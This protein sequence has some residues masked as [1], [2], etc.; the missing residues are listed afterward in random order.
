METE[1]T[2]WHL[3]LTLNALIGFMTQAVNLGLCFYFL[4]LCSPAQDCTEVM[5]DR[6]RAPR[7]GADA[8]SALDKL[9][10]C[11]DSSL[12]AMCVWIPCVPSGRNQEHC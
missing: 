3:N 1:N 9:L 12:L 10:L 5:I 11:Q 4:F 8:L 7:Q 6:R 2:L